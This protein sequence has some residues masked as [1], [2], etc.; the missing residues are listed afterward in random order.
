MYI[1]PFFEVETS[2]TQVWVSQVMN[3]AG[4]VDPPGNPQ[5][6]GYNSSKSVWWKY[7]PDETMTVT[8]TARQSTGD[9]EMGVYTGDGTY[10]NLTKVASDSDSGGGNTSALSM[11]VEEGVSY[12]IQISAYNGSTMNY[13]L[14][15]VPPRP[16]TSELTWRD[17]NVDGHWTPDVVNNATVLDP[18]ATPSPTGEPSSLS[19]WWRYAPFNSGQLILDTSGSN[20]NTEMAVYTGGPSFSNLTKVASDSD[21]A[22]GW[23]AALSMSVESGEVYWIQV[24]SYDSRP[25]T[26][27]LGIRGPASVDLPRAN[28]SNAEYVVINED[29]YT[30]SINTISLDRQAEA[31]SPTSK[32][33][34]THPA[35]WVYKPKVDGL[36]TFDTLYSGSHHAAYIF[37]GTNLDSLSMLAEGQTG[38]S[39]LTVGLQLEVLAAQTY[40]IR[41]ETYND[42]RQDLGLTVVGPPSYG[43]P[44]SERLFEVWDG[45]LAAECTLAGYWNGAQV[46][47]LEY[48]GIWNGNYPE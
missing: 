47:P 5:P 19:V 41:L 28:F 46:V 32:P 6:T 4:I 21:S 23:K 30:D 35:W 9:T 36:A 10:E 16:D 15:I 40:Y 20:N 26:Y 24:A 33:L 17:A 3:N 22:G 27:V 29:S 13:V 14:M 37:T 8:I 42:V 43:K 48:V 12:W 39:S 44:T 1:A 18:L 11:T 38:L 25:M 34:H 2:K 7:V 45:E 31:G